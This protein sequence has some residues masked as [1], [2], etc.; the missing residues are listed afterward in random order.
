MGAA[1]VGL[2]AVI[3]WQGIAR[4]PRYDVAV[5]AADDSGVSSWQPVAPDMTPVNWNVFEPLPGL[6]R[7]VTGTTLV[8]R[9]RLAGTFIVMSPDHQPVTR[10]AVV[11]ERVS[12]GDYVVREGETFQGVVVVAVLPEQVVLQ[13]GEQRETLVLDGGIGRRDIAADV[14]TASVAAGSAGAD[15]ALR[16]GDQINATRWVFERDRL[17]DYY[18]EVMTSPR[19][20][21]QVFDS[22]K[23]VYDAQDK[24][25]GYLL[26]IEGEAD[27]FTAV[28]LREGDVVLAV[29]DM[30]MSNRRRAEYL[31]G[32]FILDRLNVFILDI[33]RDGQTVKQVYEVR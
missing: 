15:G 18:Q 33:E 16:F 26:D 29:N 4:L 3:A 30:A 32:E 21:M 12:G 7:S 23:P 19:R 25:T 14:G 28:G 5:R 22:M 10:K 11:V 31:I 2:A 13:E 6:L 24:I 8:Q 17:V 1:A 9:Y 27:F 20:L